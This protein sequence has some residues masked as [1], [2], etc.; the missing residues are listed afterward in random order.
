MKAIAYLGMAEKLAVKAVLCKE[1]A[2][3]FAGMDCFYNPKNGMLADMDP[4]EFSRRYQFVENKLAKGL[5]ISREE[6]IILLIGLLLGKET[7]QELGY[8][9]L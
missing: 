3:H 5:E 4:F 7:R 8:G 6:R 9:Q 1:F 2:N